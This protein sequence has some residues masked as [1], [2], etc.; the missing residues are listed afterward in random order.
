[1]N[2]E[3]YN[4]RVPPLVTW[5]GIYFAVYCS[6]SLADTFTSNTQM[7]RRLCGLVVRISGYK[8]RAPASIFD[9][10]RFLRSSGPGTGPTQPR[11]Y[12]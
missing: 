8:S 7:Q 5:D 4:V 9:A 6:Q 11:E 3:Q 1:M 10:T 12:N 2:E